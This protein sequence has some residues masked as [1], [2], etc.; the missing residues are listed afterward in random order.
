LRAGRKSCRPLGDIAH[1]AAA[2]GE[3]RVIVEG[4]VDLIYEIHPLTVRHLPMPSFCE[5]IGHR[6]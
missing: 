6:Q 1:P 2:P 4:F 5:P 3:G